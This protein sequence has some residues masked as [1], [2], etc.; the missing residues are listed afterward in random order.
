MLVHQRV[1]AVSATFHGFS[2]GKSSQALDHPPLPWETPP[3]RCQV[4][5]EAFL[6]AWG[7]HFCRSTSPERSS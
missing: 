4:D 2:M 7:D 6:L 5:G 1:S 3:D